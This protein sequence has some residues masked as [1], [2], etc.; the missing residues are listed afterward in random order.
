M[1]AATF[2]SLSE[3]F[4]NFKFNSF[5]TS[6]LRGPKAHFDVISKTAIIDNTRIV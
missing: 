5:V 3:V 4:S 6:C 2:S 1:C